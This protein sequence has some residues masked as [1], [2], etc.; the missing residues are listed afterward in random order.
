MS[1]LRGASA[2]LLVLLGLASAGAGRLRALDHTVSHGG[3][4][5]HAAALDTQAQQAAAMAGLE[6][7]IEL[8]TQM[9][10]D[11]NEQAEDDKSNWE[12]YSE[13]SDDAEAE[14]NSFIQEQESLVMSSTAKM[15]A[16]Q[17]SIAKLTKDLAGLAKDIKEMKASIV[18]LVTMRKEEHQEF[19]AALGDVTK[20]IAAVGKA[21]EILEGHYGGASA[22]ALAEI[23]T[24][25]QMALTMYSAHQDPAVG[26]KVEAFSALLQSAVAG[27][28]AKDSAGPDYLSVDGSKYNTYEKQGGA[29]GVLSMLDDLRS[30]L[31]SQKQDLI[32]SEND[33]RRQF[34]ETKSAKEANLKHMHKVQEEKT[35][36]RAECESTVEKMRSTIDMANG[37]IAEGKAY[38]E[39]L[40]KDRATFQKQYS[41]R[42]QMRS[43]EQAATQAALDALQSVS[44]GNQVGL[45]QSQAPA[46][47]Q[48]A[49]TVQAS[50]R[51]RGALAK[52]VAIAKKAG[53]VELVQMATKAQQDYMG[54][55]QGQFYDQGNFGP[56]LKLLSDLIERLESEASAE[57]SQHEWCETEKAQSVAGK[58]EREKSIHALRGTIEQMT[59]LVAQLKTEVLFMTDEIA[60]VEKET[61]EAKKIR[62]GEKEVFDKAKADHE[63][64][65]NAIKQALAAL[66]GQYSL[67]QVSKGKIVSRKAVSHRQSPFGDYASGSGSAG[68]AM[69]M[70]QDL[71]GRYTSALRELVADEEASKKAHEELLKVNAQFIAETTALKNSK[72]KE[73]RGTI[74]ALANDKEE[75]KTHLLELHEL[76]KYLMD[77]RPSC[78]DIRTT[79]E[80]RKKRREAEI[81]AL[82]EALEVMSDPSMG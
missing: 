42:V 22:A 59:T 34:E 53:A 10:K 9:L 70:L 45:L 67:L 56:V 64:V 4:G 32:S 35:E 37:D 16:N 77:L 74:M 81:S 18:E 8:L 60:R 15:S 65:I 82:K 5:G 49:L 39:L 7:V 44:S 28:S 27:A 24:R 13:W 72:T 33:A 69:E 21:T 19:E 26:K 50:T 73:R 6:E 2:V 55:E 63:E 71:E 80:E 76:S 51:L 79:Y 52:V 17:E 57:T 40:L 3:S 48:I 1:A 31:M 36:K 14:K 75:M 29:N 11:F 58:E 30:Q 43:N 54:S 20:T 47:L 68:S 23:R 38:L 25:V 78:D 61:K 66:G 62:A 46:F 41:E 12:E